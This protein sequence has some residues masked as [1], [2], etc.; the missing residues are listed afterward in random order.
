MTDTSTIRK[1]K[2]SAY[3]D[4]KVA[5]GAIGRVWREYLMLRWG[6]DVGADPEWDITADMVAD[7]MALMKEM[8]RANPGCPSESLVDCGQDIEVYAQIATE[9]D[10]RVDKEVE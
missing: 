3:G 6:L 8:R 5:L 9:C 10:A 1:I 2:D 4:P 7:L